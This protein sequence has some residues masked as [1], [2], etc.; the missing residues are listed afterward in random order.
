MLTAFAPAPDF[1][2][3]ALADELVPLALEAEEAEAERD[4]A[5]DAEAETALVALELLAAAEDVAALLELALALALV[6]WL[7]VEVEVRRV[8]L[9]TVVDAGLDV[10]VAVTTWRASSRLLP[11]S[12]QIEPENTVLS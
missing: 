9:P 3:V 7:E 4:A 11:C 12:C 6:A 5:A 1:V 10:V 2:T 8:E